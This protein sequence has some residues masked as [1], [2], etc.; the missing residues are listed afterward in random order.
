MEKFMLLFSGSDVYQPQ[1]SPESLQVLTE[2]MIA[3][4]GNLS[5]NGLHVSSDKLQ[6]SGKKVIGFSK[7]I[8]DIPFSNGKSIIGGCTIVLAKDLDQAV[9]IAKN[10]PMLSTNASIEVRPVES[11]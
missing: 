1:Q 8:S 3:W 9:E 11:V 4:V 7:L 2:K 5:D 10:C 6:R